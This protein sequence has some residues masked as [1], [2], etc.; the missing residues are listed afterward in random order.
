L[1]H[2][3]VSKLSGPALAA[4]LVERL[5]PNTSLPSGFRAD[6][7]QAAASAEKPQKTL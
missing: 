2:A 5:K 1:C 3:H 4:D 7:A 6:G